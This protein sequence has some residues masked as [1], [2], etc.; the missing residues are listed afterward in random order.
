M[1]EHVNYYSKE[2]L[3]Y[4]YNL[5]LAGNFLDSFDHSLEI[6]DINTIIELYNVKKFIDD[7]ISLDSW[8]HEKLEEYILTCQT[9]P[10]VIG[11]FFHHI[12]SDTLYDQYIAVD[13][14]YQDDFWEL[15]SKYKVYRHISSETF[16]TVLQ[17]DIYI[18]R[19]VLYEKDL[20]YH[21]GDVIAEVLA[22]EIECA[23]LVFDHFL[24][25]HKEHRQE[26]YFPKEFDAEKKLAILNKYLDL[27]NPNPNYLQLIF[28]TKKADDFPITEKHRLKAKQKHT[29]FVKRLLSDKASVYSNLIEVGIRPQ[30]DPV[31]LEHASD[32]TFRY[33]YSLEWIEQNL[34]Y[35]TLLN[36]F[37]YLFHYVD[38]FF[39]CTFPPKRS[40]MG[41]TE[42]Y[43]GITG[44]RDYTTGFA[45]RHKNYVAIQQM[46]VYRGILQQHGIE[47]EALF[48]WF[49]ET[50]LLDEFGVKGFNY[51]RPS[52][53]TTF[54]E[55]ILLLISQMDAIIKQYK[56]FYED[57]YIDRELF[58]ISSKA[59]GITNA[60]SLVTTKKYI[61]AQSREIKKEAN[62]L[63]SD[64]SMLH[65]TEKTKDKY[66]SLPALL[67]SE[68]MCREDFH[69]YNWSSI[70]WLIERKTLFF[71]ADNYLRANPLKSGIL[72][73][74]FHNEVVCYSY[75]GDD[76]KKCI[77]EMI[78]T[79]DLEFEN[80]LFSRPEQAYLKYMLNTQQFDNGPELRNKYAH[81][82]HSLDPQVWES[83]YMQLLNIMVLMIIKINEEFC[84][85]FPEIKELA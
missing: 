47:I 10:S 58:E 65:Y 22:T 71:D 23:D 70:D 67:Q 84:L 18:V 77:D 16:F 59:E 76:L 50:Y 66:K 45:Y 9:F 30:A 17:Q 1:Q 19:F 53:S 38:K 62:A 13:I 8:Q 12:T 46:Q 69:K 85:K 39:R 36:N 82:T 28:N 7:R 64:Q 27:E 51:Y 29:E 37:I 21:Y 83:D 54:L 20:V 25:S 52:I 81:G 43:L 56:L 41:V 48:Q 5:R 3:S 57:G 34:D 60:P 40:E 14:D 61:Y 11:K 15:F 80:S 68:K 44:L 4:S 72:S 6:N 32:N 73:Q 49:F 55:K 75:L 63:F 78:A 24:A 2:D 79:G 35:P 42:R 31:S 26:T 33:F 74:L